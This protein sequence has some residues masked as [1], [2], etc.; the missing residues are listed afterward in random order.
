ML[1]CLFFFTPHLSGA[2]FIVKAI[3]AT[4][5]GTGD[6]I[7][8]IESSSGYAKGAFIS[9]RLGKWTDK[10][11]AK[12]WRSW[13]FHFLAVSSQNSFL[14][15]LREPSSSWQLFVLAPC[16]TFP[17]EVF[18]GCALAWPRSSSSLPWA[19]RTPRW[20]TQTTAQAATRAEWWELA[21]WWWAVC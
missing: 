1:Y 9:F 3:K 20:G 11:E 15:A 6:T 10:A 4:P 12:S 5:S 17:A 13:H 14:A 8:K 16:S 19:A 7:W 21:F 18:L 2:S